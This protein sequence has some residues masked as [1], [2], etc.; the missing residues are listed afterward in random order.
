MVIFLAEK[1]ALCLL[2][3]DVACEAASVLHHKVLVC[4]SFIKKG[5]FAL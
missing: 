3:N 1:H 5:T 2:Q 4:Y